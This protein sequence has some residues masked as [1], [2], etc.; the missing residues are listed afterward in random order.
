MRIK[1]L[2]AAMAF[3]AT[4]GYQAW[5]LEDVQAADPV[6]MGV[7]SVGT[8]ITVGSI[9]DGL[10]ELVDHAEQAAK[11]VSLEVFAGMHTV[12]DR[13]KSQFVDVLDKRVDELSEQM[14]VQ[15]KELEFLVRET[16]ESV[17]K[18]PSCIGNELEYAEASL[19]AGIDDSIRNLPLVSQGE[20][21]I[22]FAHESGYKRP[23]TVR[24]D[25][26]E[27]TISLRGTNL[28]HGSKSCDVAAYITD[29]DGGNRKELSILS[30]NYR[31]YMLHAPDGV[32]SG[33]YLIHLEGGKKGFLWGCKDKKKLKT[34]ISSI[35]LPALDVE[36]TATPY[37]KN[38]DIITHRCNGSVTNGSCRTRWRYANQRCQFP[39][40]SYTLKEHKFV[41]TKNMRGNASATRQG[42]DVVVQ[43]RARGR[44]RACTRGTGNVQ[45]YVDLIGTKTLTPFEKDEYKSLGKIHLNHSNDAIFELPIHEEI[46]AQCEVTDWVVTGRA[47]S[48]NS[49][50]E[51]SYVIGPEKID[52]DG[53]FS[54]D[55]YPLSV[56]LE[57]PS[58]KGSAKMAYSSC[59]SY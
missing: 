52:N 17:N 40:S 58:G 28:W 36:I 23:Y 46:G 35:P 6:S 26:K 25:A 31:E 55:R 30:S 41:I 34:M 9:F 7:S 4:L 22:L 29:L 27:K 54:V 37:C 21:V 44:G 32:K 13:V 39:D 14:Q 20:P 5:V 59:L 1:L 38:E 19:K 49:E 42:N 56:K 51:L 50:E 3:T 24:A 48:E 57:M 11:G 15:I 47:L 8:A 12:I 16:T 10:H 45:W 43:A 33:K 53:V 2:A 18:L